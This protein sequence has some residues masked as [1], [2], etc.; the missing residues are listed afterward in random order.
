M[1]AVSTPRSCRPIRVCV[2]ELPRTLVVHLK[3]FEFDMEVMQRVK[4]ND[5]F[6]VCWRP[7]RV[8]IR[9]GYFSVTM[10][11]SSGQFVLFFFWGGG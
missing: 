10:G 6:A 2:K 9:M 7:E 11:K 8:H 5:C 3:R 1:F 4:V